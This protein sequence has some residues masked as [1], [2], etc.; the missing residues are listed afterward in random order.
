MGCLVKGYQGSKFQGG[1]STRIVNRID[2]S[3]S[4]LA[5]FEIFRDMSGKRYANT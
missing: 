3:K 5:R 2:G 1:K 4:N